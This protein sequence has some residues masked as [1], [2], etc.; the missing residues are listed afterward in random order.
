MPQAA[1]YATEGLTILYSFPHVLGSPGIGT[2]AL[3]QVRGLVGRGHAVHLVAADLATPVDGLASCTRSLAVGGVRIR[4]RLTGRARAY[5]WHDRCARLRLEQS[6]PDVVHVWPSGSLHTLRRA[7][8]LGVPGLRESPNT[9]VVNSFESVAREIGRLDLGRLG[10][11][12]HSPDPR[13]LERELMELELASHVL[14][15]SDAVKQTYLDAGMSA[16]RLLR[17]QYGATQ[18]STPPPGRDPASPFTAVFVGR[19][20]PRKGVHHALTA[21]S[22]SKAAAAG[23]RFILIGAG[24]DGYADYLGR[25]SGVPGVEFRAFDP[26]PMRLMAQSDVLLLPS[27]EEGSALVTYEA[28][29]VGCVPLVSDAAGAMVTDGETGLVHA[30]GDVPALVRHLD[31]AFTEPQRL[32]AMREAVLA[33]APRLSWEAAAGRL[34][35]AYEQAIL[36]LRTPSTTADA[37][38]VICTRNRPQLLE[39]ALTRIEAVGT[40]ETE[41]IVVDSAS[42]SDETR[43]VADRFPG[44]RYR[45][46]ERPGL[47]IARNEGLKATDRRIVVFT[48]DDCLPVE[49]WLEHAVAAFDRTRVA[50]VTGA[51]HGLDSEEARR[52]RPAYAKT[53]SGLDAGHGAVMAFDRRLVL[54]L[55]GFDPLLGAGAR[56]SGAEDLDM[57]CR[58][59]STGRLIRHEQRF[60]VVHA[61]VRIGEELVRL[62]RGYGRGLG[63]MLAKWWRLSPGDAFRMSARTG[64]RSL[65]AV[66]RLRHPH[67]PLVPVALLLGIVEGFTAALRKPVSGA[68]L[69]ARRSEWPPEPPR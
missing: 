24:V 69:S 47:S 45:R 16:E 62:H 52:F 17:T 20:E 13:R 61:N 7:R 14:V 18:P 59:L 31:L 65:R 10:V 35:A 6:P 44:V 41:V 33:A 15:P 55:G 11:T 9:H 32:A 67:G 22:R 66:L 36:A 30:A 50:A 29:M 46:V 63:G 27:V 38:L 43:V 58:V 64:V 57:F 37:A 5:A 26:D 1:G 4:P 2:T 34:E 60:A 42:D 8:E 54:R 3:H 21:W 39:S 25:W 40:G 49:G 53:T 68:V 23:G 51:M 19:Q 48:D 56:W 28:Q 12:A